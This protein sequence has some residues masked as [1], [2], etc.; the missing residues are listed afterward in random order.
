M[1]EGLPTIIG[2][3]K[4]DGGRSDFL[5]TEN[6]PLIATGPFMPTGYKH[7][8]PNERET[9]Q[10]TCRM[11]FWHFQRPALDRGLNR[12][13][14]P[15]PSCWSKWLLQGAL[16]WDR[17]RGYAPGAMLERQAS[18]SAPTSVRSCAPSERAALLPAMGPAPPPLPALAAAPPR[19]QQGLFEKLKELVEW[20]EKGLLSATEFA[21]AK[22][23]LGLC[24][25]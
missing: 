19:G 17:D 16:A 5:Y 2:V 8:A 25:G 4:S 12:D 3:P 11:E 7:G 23:Q 14:Q 10:L 9:E 18:V 13:L 20:Y 22:K 21:A 1:L 24:V 6:A 15:C